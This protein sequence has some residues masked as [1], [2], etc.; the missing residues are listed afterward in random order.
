MSAAE[1]A[2]TTRERIVDAAD[3]LFYQRGFEKT[4]FAD[5][6]DAVGLSRGNF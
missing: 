2:P 6:A 5:I 4:S 3:T 1:A